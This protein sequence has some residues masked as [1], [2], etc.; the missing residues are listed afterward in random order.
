MREII[1]RIISARV[2]VVVYVAPSGSRAASAG[3][4]ITM[5]AHVAAMAPGTSTGAAHPLMAIGFFAGLRLAE[6][7]FPQYHALTD[8][9]SP[10]KLYCSLD[11]NL[12]LSVGVRRSIW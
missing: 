10:T 2:P 1:K 3:A 8:E 7:A 9:G 12:N 5:S 4:Y 6:T 11:K